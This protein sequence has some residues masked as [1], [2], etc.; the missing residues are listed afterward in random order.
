MKRAMH[1][2]RVFQ[3]GEDENQETSL[4]VLLIFIFKSYAKYKQNFS[5]H[6]THNLTQYCVSESDSS[7]SYLK[8]DFYGG[9]KT[10]ICFF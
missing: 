1:S 7:I 9:S 2:I 4:F 8:F 10:L 3:K 6:G 5:P